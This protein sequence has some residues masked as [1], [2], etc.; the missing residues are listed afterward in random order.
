MGKSVASVTGIFALAAVLFH[1]ARAPVAEH[2][3]TPDAD[4]SGTVEAAASTPS[5]GKGTRGAVP[6]GPWRATQQYFHSESNESDSASSCLP[7]ASECSRADLL[8]FYGLPG[9]ADASRIH[10]LIATVPDPLHTRLSMQTD[11]FLDAIQEAAFRSGYELATEWLPWNLK[12]V[13]EDT[14]PAESGAQS[15]APQSLPGLIVFRPHFNPY[16]KSNGDL[17]LVWIVGESPTTGI[18]GFQFNFARQTIP[19]LG[20]SGTQTIAIAG[21]TFSG[22]FLSLTR[23]IEESKEPVHFEVRSGTA[24]NS[25][26]AREMLIELESKGFVLDP[27]QPVPKSVTFYSAT[28]PNISFHNHLMR[29]AEKLR[30]PDNQVAELV[31]DETGFSYIDTRLHRHIESNTETVTYRYPRDIAQLRNTYNDSAFFSSPASET[32]TSAK[33]TVDFSL[34]DTQAGEDAFPTFSTSHTPLSQNAQLAQ[35]AHYLSRR[36]IRLLSLSATNV[37]DELFLANVLAR[38]CPDTRIVLPAADLLFVQDAARGSLSG[39]MAISPFPLFP[40]GSETSRQDMPAGARL[41]VTTFASSDQIAEFNAVLSLI[42]RRGSSQ[43]ARS[44][45]EPFMPKSSPHA[46]SSTW[47]LVLSPRG[48]M[49]VDLYG[50]WPHPI[51]VHHRYLPWFDA[52]EAPPKQANL[53]AGL[54]V[55]RPGWTFLCV[56]VALFSFGFASRLIFLQLHPDKRVWSVLCLSDLATPE[57]SRAISSTVHRRYICML[58]SFGTLA[59]VNGFLLCPMV[60]AAMRF[61]EPSGIW[62]DML[63]VGLAFALCLGTFFYVAKRAPVRVYQMGAN[64][65][66]PVGASRSYWSV[67]LRLAIVAILV[68]TLWA[69][70][71]CCDNGA[72]G[73]MLC[74]RSLTLAAPVSPIWPL[75]LAGFGLFALAYFHLRRFTWCDRRQPRLDTSVFDAALCDEFKRIRERLEEGLVSNLGSGGTRGLWRLVAAAVVLFIAVWLLVP[76]GSLSSFDPPAFSRVLEFLL[77]ILA[78]YTISTFVRFNRYWSFLRAFLVGLNS[79]AIGRFFRRV[80]EFG[81]GGPVWVREVKLMS[82]A[83]AVNSAIA[84]HNLEVM[85]TIPET[86]AKSYID[87]LRNFLSPADGHG[88][89]LEFINAYERFRAT[90]NDIS[91]SLSKDVLVRYWRKNELPFVGTITTEAEEENARPAEKKMAAAAGA[92]KRL[93]SLMETRAGHSAARRAIQANETPQAVSE[94]AYEQAGTYVA[95]HYSAYIGYGLHQLQNLVLSCV[96]CFVF[97]VAALNSF[98]FQSPQ[99]IFH[100]LTGGLIIGGGSVLVAFAQMERDPILS[101]LSGTSEGELGKDFYMRAL[102][103]SALPVLSVL[104]SEFPSISRYITGW[105][106]PASAALQ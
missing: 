6:S 91:A 76:R 15:I 77:F 73:Y 86:Y 75:M 5:K 13:A 99:T 22:S 101:R 23:L 8:T 93:H 67:A 39:L 48:W 30:V 11:R 66:C 54:L 52:N 16:S 105:L 41:D 106:Q 46:F 56:A 40:E 35:I 27:A 3:R 20:S 59:M 87:E 72:T 68:A 71:S 55:A 7:R 65:W 44:L 84:L 1:S 51:R 63:M 25:D 24:S 103:Y 33:P 28:I 47:L 19:R 29:L 43:S 58:L 90:A 95:L 83:S 61:S 38:D 62:A 34:K 74:F 88:T 53:L 31:E 85:G 50:Q 21:P 37:F 98:S 18:N 36:S 78:L 60:A 17:L 70:W 10:S 81:G 49:P 97:L 12:Y 4:G 104:A 89:R 32:D 26:Y 94:E 102:A 80:P 9:D 79:V 14:A 57:R 2:A 92:G 64:D 45:S 96:I 42:P 82:L 100:I 69:W